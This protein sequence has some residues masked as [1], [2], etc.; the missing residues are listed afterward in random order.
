MWRT[1]TILVTAVLLL[2][3]LGI[4]MLAS[5]SGVHGNALFGDPNYFVKRQAAALVLGLL[6][7]ILGARID[8]QVWKKFA[9]PLA[10]ITFLLLAAVLVPGIGIEVKGSRRWISLGV[11]TMQ[12]SEIGKVALIFLLAWWMSRVKRKAGELVPGLI[13]PG[14]LMGALIL[15]VLVGPDFGTSMLMGAVGFAMLWAGGSRF[16]HLAIA[17]TGAA[18]F[19]T[20]L[21]MQN[22]VRMRRI[23]AFL[24]PERYADREAFQLLNA[25]YAFVMGGSGG[26]GL[27]ASLQKRYYLPESHTDFI[28]AIIG[29]EL[30]LAASMGVLLLF[31][32]IFVCGLRISAR[33]PD[34]FGRLAAL[35][36]TCMIT[37]QAAINLGVVTGCLPTKGLPLPFI[38]YGGTSLAIT[39]GMV[40]VLVGIARQA[41]EDGASL[42]VVRDRARRV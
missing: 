7:A 27:G 25:I 6:A 15:P 8:Y 1:T 41:G 31:A 33:A 35:G 21:I 30:G 42:S 16:S 10:G 13:I 20:V 38:S 23:I 4:V 24:D 5:T 36:L 3:A 26:V 34:S 2:V 39:L 17:G 29:E 11:T 9:V 14:A 19:M 40:G 18:S 37:I 22:E 32:V 28:F 12:P